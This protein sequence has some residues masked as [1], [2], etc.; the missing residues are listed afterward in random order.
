MADRSQSDWTTWA[1]VA[2]SAGLLGG[3]AYVGFRGSRPFIRDFLDEGFLLEDAFVRPE[4]GRRL[5]AGSSG[6]EIVWS[7]SPLLVDGDYFRDEDALV[8]HMQRAARGLVQDREAGETWAYYKTKIRRL[9]EGD[10]IK[11]YVNP[12]DVDRRDWLSDETSGE[13]FD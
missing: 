7:E 10:E 6:Y 4:I 3:F 9:P 5:R 12:E 11:V 13:A 8:H 1:L 2:A